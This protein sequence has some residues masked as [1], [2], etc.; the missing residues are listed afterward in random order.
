MNILSLTEFDKNGI[1]LSVNHNYSHTRRKGRTMAEE[2][3]IS[4]ED[5]AEQLGVTRT[6]LY[7]YIRT[8]KL[9]KKKFELDKRVY[10]KV[11]DFQRIKTLKDEAAKRNEPSVA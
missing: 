7:Y 8:L 11:S 9:E 1:L 4:M 2:K 5:A 10:L 3:Y 6:A